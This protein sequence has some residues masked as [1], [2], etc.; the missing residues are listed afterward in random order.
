MSTRTSFRPRPLDTARQLPLVRSLSELDNDEALVSRS[1]HH[2]HITLD[3]ENEEVSVVLRN[4]R[5]LC[6]ISSD[7]ESL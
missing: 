1:V 3:A 2:S 6:S 4:P 7:V 5:G